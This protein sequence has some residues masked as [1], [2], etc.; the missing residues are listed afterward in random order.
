MVDDN[1]LL[2]NNPFYFGLHA[3]LSCLLSQASE[4]IPVLIQTTLTIHDLYNVLQ[5]QIVQVHF[6][7]GKVEVVIIYRWF[8]SV[9]S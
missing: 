9:T 3:F 8:F 7:G 1:Q 4:E 2:L 5:L 6:S